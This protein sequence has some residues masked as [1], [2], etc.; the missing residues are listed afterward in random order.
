MPKYH[1][2]CTS[3]ERGYYIYHGMNEDHIKCV[4]CGEETIHRVPE[5]PF[6]RR[7][8]KKQGGKVGDAVRSAIEENRAI[9]KDAKEAARNKE[10]EPEK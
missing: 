6:I 3:C 1:Y 2:T 8:T 4:H 10:W 5:M 7:E 9:L